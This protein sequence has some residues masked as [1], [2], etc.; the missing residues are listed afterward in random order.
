ME[1]PASWFSLDTLD[2]KITAVFEEVLLREV[3]PGHML[4]GVPVQAI[5]KC[6]AND[7]VLF[8][9]LDGS[10]RVADVHLTWTGAFPERPPWPLAV[11]Y[12]G[13]EAWLADQEREE[14]W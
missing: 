6:E 3:G 8:R 4:Y 11:L 9:L 2:P 13:L 7:D 10:G 12:D 1:W 5:A 14:E